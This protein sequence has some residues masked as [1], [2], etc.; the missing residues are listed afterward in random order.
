MYNIYVLYV[1]YWTGELFYILTIV[2]DYLKRRSKNK[3]KHFL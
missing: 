3:I 2:T 1:I